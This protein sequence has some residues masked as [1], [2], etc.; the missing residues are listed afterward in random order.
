L[1][2]ID[3]HIEIPA[4]KYKELTE[5]GDAELSKV[6]KARVEK[7]RTIQRERF[8]NEGVFYNASMNTKLTKK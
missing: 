1:D 8:K 2:R 6:I 3:I 5:T 4:V 7:T